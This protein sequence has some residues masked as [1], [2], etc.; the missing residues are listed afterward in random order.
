MYGAFPYI[1]LICMVNVGKYTSPMDC[2][3]YIRGTWRPSVFKNLWMVRYR[4]DY[5]E[6]VRS[7]RRSLPFAPD[8]V[9]LPHS[10]SLPF[11]FVYLDLRPFGP[12]HESVNQ[13]N[14]Q[15]W[16]CQVGRL[17]CIRGKESDKTESKPKQ[18]WDSEV[19]SHGCSAPQMGACHYRAGW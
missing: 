15:A 5:E 17:L 7:C 12:L 2:L 11:A 1:W 6:R 3:G 13:T 4:S 9:R 18:S 19:A 14:Y 8:D 16:R 10:E